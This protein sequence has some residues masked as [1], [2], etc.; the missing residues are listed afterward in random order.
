[1]VAVALLLY[2]IFKPVNRNPSWLAAFFNFVGLTFWDASIES[3][4]R[5]HPRGIERILLL[6]G[7]LP[8]FQVDLSASIPGRSDNVCRFGLGDLSVTTTRKLSVP[9]Q[10]GPRHPRAGR[11]ALKMTTRALPLPILAPPMPSDLMD[12]L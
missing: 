6:P 5:G 11:P 1:M 4:G 2:G 9:L 7:R 12:A 8:H 3:S 10:S